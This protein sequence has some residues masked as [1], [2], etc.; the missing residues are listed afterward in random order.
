MYRGGVALADGGGAPRGERR[1]AEDAAGERRP[2]VRRRVPAPPRLGAGRGDGARRRARPAV[3]AGAADRADAAGAAVVARAVDHP[4]PQPRPQDV[5]VPAREL[6]P[7]RR[8][9]RAALR[10]ER[11]V[12]GGGGPTA[13]SSRRCA[14]RRCSRCTSTRPRRGWSRSPRPRTTWTTSASPNSASR[15]TLAANY[16]LVELL[17]TGSCEDLS[18]RRTGCSC[19]SMS[20]ADAARDRHAGHVQP[21]LL[22]AQGDAGFWQISPARRS[23]RCRGE[24]P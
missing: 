13:R 15:S 12:G 21:R 11:R 14:R 19:C 17:I 5:R 20:E 10:R 16:E 6:L 8:R 7:L 9:P 18:S 3:E 1:A 4:P 23:T 2:P 24:K 22:P